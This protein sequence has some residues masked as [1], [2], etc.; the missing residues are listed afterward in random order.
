MNPI[1]FATAIR[2]FSKERG[3]MERY[4]VG[5]CDHMAEE[6]FEVHVYTE[7]WDEENPRIHFHHVRTIPFPKSLRLLS[8][9]VRATREIERGNYPLSLGVGHTLR[10]DVFQPHGGVHW[11]WF[12]R[13]LRAYDRRFLWILKFLGRILSP[14]QWVSGWIEG[15]PYRQKEPP[16]VIA[17]SDMVKE[18]II[19][20]YAIPEERITVIYN[21]VDLER[22]SPGNR[23]YRN[24][25][26]KRHRLGEEKVILFVSNNF[27]MKGLRTLM[28]A[29]AL[30]KKEGGPSL[31]LLVLGR[32]RKAPFLRLATKL[33]IS[34]EV[35]FAG[36]T[37]E[38]EK[39]YG[40]ADLLVHP[41]FYDACSLTVIEALS[42]GL[43]V[44][45]SSANGA[46][47]IVQLGERARVIDDP[48]KVDQ[49]SQA[50]RDLLVEEGSP[51]RS[52]VEF[53][54]EERNYLQM[55]EVFRQVARGQGG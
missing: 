29:L 3:G 48:Q 45:T 20:W 21:G 9:A 22:F 42:S 37:A 19:R 17:I 50:I 44:L 14:A 24:S 38:P 30:L 6:G 7:R 33:G 43:P 8:F 15:A 49:V 35:L 27:R 12:W 16:K 36:S 10:A 46:S 40:A 47:G 55:T 4:L 51:F 54:S 52:R 34:E 11:A 5:L 13:S 18:D 53:F 31:K 41:T 2:Q 1:R 25:I 39:Y 32:D 26:R 23:Q 28:E